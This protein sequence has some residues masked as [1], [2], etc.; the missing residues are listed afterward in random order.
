[1]GNVLE[2]IVWHRKNEPVLNLISTANRNVVEHA[3]N[4]REWVFRLKSA[5]TGCRISTVTKES[6]GS[7]PRVDCRDVHDFP[8]MPIPSGVS[9]AKGVCRPVRGLEMCLGYPRVRT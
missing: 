2:V 5:G 1:M 6:T 4:S 7:V 8:A 9:R 3:R